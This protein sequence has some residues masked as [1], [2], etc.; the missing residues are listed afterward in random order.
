MSDLPDLRA[1]AEHVEVDPDAAIEAARLIAEDRDQGL[2]F[3][4]EALM[5]QLEAGVGLD[6]AVSAL[7][8]AT[9]PQDD[10]GL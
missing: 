3:V 9:D 5:E 6:A 8:N 7:K 4:A 10:D 1:V 2:E